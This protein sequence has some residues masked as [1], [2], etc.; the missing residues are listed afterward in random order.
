MVHVLLLTVS[1]TCYGK[2]HGGKLPGFSRKITGWFLQCILSNSKSFFFQLFKIISIFYLCLPT[3]SDNRTGWQK[4]H[5]L[6][7]LPANKHMGA[8][9]RKVPLFFRPEARFLGFM[10]TVQTQFRRHKMR[11]L[12]RIYTVCLQKFLHFH[13]IPNIH[14][15]I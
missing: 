13:Q 15:T 9:F 14:L 11:R 6:V 12:I 3:L 5:H 4:R 1:H 10:Q 2:R 8:V 7:L